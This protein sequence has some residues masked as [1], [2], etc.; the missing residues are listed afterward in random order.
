MDDKSTID[1]IDYLNT[2]C[3]EDGVSTVGVK[4]GRIFMFTV[5]KLRELIGEAEINGEDKV[6]IF[7]KEAGLVS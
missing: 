7:V 4:D 5:E 1:V 3:H 2:K 6:L